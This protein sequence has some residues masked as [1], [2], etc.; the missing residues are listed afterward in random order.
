MVNL[1]IREE[2]IYKVEEREKR[3]ILYHKNP[4]MWY[5]IRKWVRSHSVERKRHPSFLGTGERQKNGKLR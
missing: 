4:N 5:T 2:G 1:Q 3:N